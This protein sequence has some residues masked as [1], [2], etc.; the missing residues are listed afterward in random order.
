MFIVKKHFDMSRLI[1]AVC[2]EEIFGSVF[3]EDNFVLNLSSSFFRGE[4]LSEQELSELMKH[5]YIM[6]LAGESSVGLAVRL[7]FVKPDAVRR[8]EG[9][10]FAFY[11]NDLLR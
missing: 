10:P 4:K 11:V 9:V 2:D 6:N 8:I 1:L 7:G 3:K 5:A